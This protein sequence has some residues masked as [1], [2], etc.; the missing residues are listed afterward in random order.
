MNGPRLVVNL[1]FR[2]LLIQV[3]AFSPGVIALDTSVQFL[4]PFDLK[5]IFTIAKRPNFGTLEVIRDIAI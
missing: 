1:V 4:T 3:I 5:A 2:V